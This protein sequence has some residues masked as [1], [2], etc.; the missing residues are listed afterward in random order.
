MRIRNVAL[1]G[2]GDGTEHTAIGH[3]GQRGELDLLSKPL[4][5]ERERESPVPIR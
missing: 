2:A 3:T 4:F 5:H 1:S